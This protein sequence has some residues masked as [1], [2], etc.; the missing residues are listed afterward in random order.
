ML[1]PS[2]DRV[3]RYFPLTVAQP[4][5]PGHA[6]TAVLG[7]ADSWFEQ[8]ETLLLATL[9]EGAGSRCSIRASRTWAACRRQQGALQRLRRIAA[10]GRARRA[11]PCQR[12]GRT[13][14][15]RSSLW[16]GRGSQRI[17]AGLMRCA[18][19]RRPPI[20]AVFFWQGASI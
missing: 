6:L 4:L 19:C 7:G 20:S 18:A 12:P 3:G 16:W 10:P 1:M 9:E 15:R 2:I 13:G 14:L 5:D 17:E 11:E 8:V